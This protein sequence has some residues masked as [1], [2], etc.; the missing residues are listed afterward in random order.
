MALPKIPTCAPGR[1]G[2][3]PENIREDTSS[4]GGWTRTV[5]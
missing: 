4:T 1:P 5:S 2:E 3:R